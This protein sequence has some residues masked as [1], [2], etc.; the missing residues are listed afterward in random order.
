MQ[1]LT[2]QEQVLALIKKSGLTNAEQWL[3]KAISAKLKAHQELSRA[4]IDT[5]RAAGDRHGLTAKTS[6]H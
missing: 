6:I 2:H 1:I 5:I 3:L 4:D